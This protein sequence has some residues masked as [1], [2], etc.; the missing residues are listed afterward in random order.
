MSMVQYESTTTHLKG[1]QWVI[2]QLLT[3]AGQ[4]LLALRFLEEE[5]GLP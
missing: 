1:A 5:T 2:S 3:A 4:N